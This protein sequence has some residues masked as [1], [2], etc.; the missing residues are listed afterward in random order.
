VTF[1]DKKKHSIQREFNEYFTHL[2]TVNA[3]IS[4]VPHPAQTF[5]VK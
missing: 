1:E 3:Q 2:T 4:S 5:W